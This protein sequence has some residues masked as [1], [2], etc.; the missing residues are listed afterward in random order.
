MML[1]L[2]IMQAA[3]LADVAS[4]VN[5]YRMYT[6]GVFVCIHP[7]VRLGDATFTPGLVA[8]VNSGKFKQCDPGDYDYFSGPPNF[9]F[10]VY[11]EEQRPEI[12][13]R[14]QMFE[15]A[16]VIEYV[17]WNNTENRP[18]WLRLVENKLIEVQMNDGE[19]IES[20]ALPGMRFPVTAFKDRDWRSIM[21]AIS[22]GI[23]R[24]PHHDF[25][26]TIWRK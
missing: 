12:E 16:G 5:H 18:A 2:D 26:A 25:M 13:R 11:H 19:V 8:Q 17:L 15:A 14:R 9:V 1:H 4:C 20:V 22:T 10:D 24:L 23:T 7:Q 6:P 3:T 21:A